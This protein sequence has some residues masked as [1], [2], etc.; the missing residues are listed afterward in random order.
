MPQLPR[1][2]GKLVC[3]ASVPREKGAPG[4]VQALMHGASLKDKDPGLPKAAFGMGGKQGVSTYQLILVGGWFCFVAVGIE[5]E[6]GVA[7]DGDEGL[8]VP[9]VLHKVHNGLDL[10]FRIGKLAVVSF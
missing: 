6:L 7:V 10:H 2:K 8:D 1:K 4:P 5:E 9:V 3:P